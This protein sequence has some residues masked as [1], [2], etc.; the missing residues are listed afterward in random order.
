MPL[1]GRRSHGSHWE[2]HMSCPEKGIF[3]FTLV[4]WLRSSALSERQTLR[5]LERSLS[6]SR[7]FF[8]TNFADSFFLMGGA[9][10]VREG[11]VCTDSA[12][13]SAVLFNKVKGQNKRGVPFYRARCC[14]SDKHQHHRAHNAPEKYPRVFCYRR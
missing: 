12:G 6:P 10:T 7:V 14:T 4:C 13:F 2:G 3:I 1:H 9:D 5:A 8:Y 11:R